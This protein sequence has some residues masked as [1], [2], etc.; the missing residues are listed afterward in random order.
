MGEALVSLAEEIG[1]AAADLA[2]DPFGNY[3]V[4]HVLRKCP[5]HWVQRVIASNLLPHLV[6]LSSQK[7]SSNVV[8]NRT[9][10]LNASIL[11]EMTK[12]VE[13][14]NAT[15]QEAKEAQDSV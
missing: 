9:K 12:V 13:H 14:I 3:V 2:Q 10:K 1:G 5:N 7:F 11:E 4:Q 8:E 15:E 6:L